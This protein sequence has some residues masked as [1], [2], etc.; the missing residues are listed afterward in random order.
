MIQRRLFEVKCTACGKNATVPFKP[1]AEKPVYCNDCF[2]NTI[3]YTKR[4]E[5][6]GSIFDS[7]NAWAR[8][9]CD[10]TGRKEK[11]PA[12]IFEKY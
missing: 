8:R 6:S 7:K 1:K 2:S 4:N 5:N 12:S 10:F 11:E 9:G 3:K